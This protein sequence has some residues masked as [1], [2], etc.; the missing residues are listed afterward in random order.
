MFE[1]GGE[2]CGNNEVEFMNYAV[3]LTLLLET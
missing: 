2:E 1:V 3:L